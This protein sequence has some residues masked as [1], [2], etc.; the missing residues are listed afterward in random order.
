MLLLA[1]AAAGVL[2][3]GLA[4]PAIAGLGLT[5]RQGVVTFENLP[6][7]LK[8]PPLPQRSVIEAADGS[9]VTSFYSEDRVSVTSAQIPDVMRTSIV[10][11]EDSRFYSHHG[12]DA[13]G[14]L[15]A[16]VK[17]QQSGRIEQGA[18]TLTQQ[19]VK[20][21]LLQSANTQE[22]QQ[23]A[24]AET[25]ARKLQEARYAIA[26]EQHLSKK[27]I[28]TRYLNIALFGPGV[29]GVGTAATS[30]FGKS[31]KKLTLPEAAMLAGLAQNPNRY[32]P[33]QHPS[34]TKERRNTVL[35]RMAQTGAIT[36]KQAA[37]AEKAPLGLHPRKTS[38]GCLKAR[39]SA[40][41]C[42]YVVQYLLN[43]SQFGAT[44]AARQARLYKGGLTI[45][46]SMDPRLEHESQLATGATFQPSSR[47]AG[48]QAV[49]EPGTGYIRALATSRPFTQDQNIYAAKRFQTGSTA[50]AFVLVAAL[51]KGLPL[52]TTIYSPHDYTSSVFKNGSAPYSISND[53][54]GMHG[55]YNMETAFAASVNTYYVQLE[56]RTGVAAAV[57][58]AKE[59]GVTSSD[60]DNYAKGKY[61]SFTLGA[62][63]ISPLDMADAYATIAAKGVQCD[64]TPILSI[65]DA[66]GNKVDAGAKKCHQAIDPGVAAAAA[67]AMTWPVNPAGPVI[68]G[69]TATGAAV[70]GHTIAGKTGTT[71]DI[72]EA[73]FV[74]F[75]GQL[76]VASVVIDP[77]HQVTLPGGDASNQISVA[78]FQRFMSAAL[79]NKPNITF[80]TPPDKLLYGG[81][82]PTP[83]PTQSVSVPLV[84]GQD[85][86][87]AISQVLGAGLGYQIQHVSASTSS[88]TVISTS[89]GAGSQVPAGSIIILVVSDGPGSTSGGGGSNG[90]GGNSGGG[91]GGGGDQTNPSPSPLPLPSPT[92]TC[93][94]PLACHSPAPNIGAG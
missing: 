49:V 42:S 4:V 77:K 17:N 80:P 56:E 94:L 28:L 24:I 25:P 79:A 66:D 59:M 87:S 3:A 20:N 78:A 91:S 65:T 10:S 64:P 19:Y 50:K 92:P 69:A 62:A 58:A 54:S 60:V 13:K 23:A 55:D 47:Y 89:P 52:D 67:E 84:D 26:L 74:G 33:L 53:S 9:F 32:D 39:I 43:D 88:G 93:R 30:Y 71:Q 40:Q 12:V 44:P 11:I 21:V 38:N 72:K 75:S 16:L 18:S 83:P 46:T 15:R 34:V 37:A 6:G 41:F 81:E 90:G 14:I 5:A 48:V 51:Q 61:G 63:V 86:G 36:N 27:E 76:S 1:A 70:S 22:Q 29:Y 45:R 8:V 82:Q 85:R 57:K 73:W 7:D 2:V 31:V 35:A 68:N